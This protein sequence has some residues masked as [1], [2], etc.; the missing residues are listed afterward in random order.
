[1][2]LLAALGT[3]LLF[4]GLGVLVGILTGL[5]PGLHVN[6]V[7]ALVV[8]TQGAW[9]TGLSGIL[10]VLAADPGALAGSLSAF[11]VAAAVSHGIFDFIPSTFL[12]AP[13]EETALS[14]L[15]GHRMLLRGEGARAV[16]LAARGALLGVLLSV[17]LLVPLRA[18]LADPVGLADRSR[19][20]TGVFLIALL[21]ALLASEGFRRGRRVRRILRA[22]WVQT[23]A[24][25]LGVA[26]LRGASGVSEDIVLFPLFSGLFGLPGLLL[27]ARAR[28]GPIPSQRIETQGRP[29][30]GELG[31]SVRGSLAGAAVSWLP[32]LSGGAAATLATLGSRRGSDPASYMVVLGSVSSSTAVLSVAVL[33]VI[34]R[35]RSGAAAA[36]RTLLGATPPWSELPSVPTALVLLLGSAVLAASVSAPIAVRLARRVASKW[37]AMD[38]RRLAVATLVGL[39]ALLLLLAGPAGFAMA[40]AATAIG[41]VPVVAGVRRVHLMASLL[42][43]VLLGFL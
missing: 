9:A 4:S 23:L 22:A 40:A 15:P 24:A 18:V 7:A 14:V 28:V 10:P 29:A 26:V 6:N 39:G 31:A 30:P 12:G 19:A 5:A 35:A 37:S 13:S 43:P 34:G 1:V 20:W 33:F 42:V 16:E 41:L 3:L 36:V 2:D 21:A 38:P 25:A 11:I 8:A 27:A 32:G 17:A